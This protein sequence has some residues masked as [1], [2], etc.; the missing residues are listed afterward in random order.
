ML[1]W[2]E[3]DTHSSFAVQ[4]DF[5]RWSAHNDRHPLPRAAREEGVSKR[6]REGGIKKKA[7]WLASCDKVLTTNAKIRT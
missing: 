2:R 1:P 7:A 3:T 5:S 4:A 6:K